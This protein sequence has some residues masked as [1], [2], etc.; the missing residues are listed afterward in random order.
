MKIGILGCGWVGERLVKHL[1]TKQYSIATTNTNPIKTAS[2]LEKG[3]KAFTLDF[4]KDTNQNNETV[5]AHFQTLDTIIISVPLSRKLDI[6]ALTQR[7]QKVTN[8]LQPN[9]NHQL[10]FLSSIG[11]Y[12]N[13]NAEINE[14]FKDIDSLKPTIYAVETLLKKHFPT[15]N[16][17]RLGGIFGDNRIFSKYF[18]NRVLENGLQ[19][20][21]H[22]HYA[23]IIG[24]IECVIKQQIKNKTINI[25][26]PQHPTKIELIEAQTTKYK[27]DKPTSIKRTKGDFKIITSKNILDLNYTFKQPNPALF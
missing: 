26:A 12:P 6:L 10:I 11:I 18:S 9:H 3:C 4:D 1:K 15:I 14:D 7:F 13:I 2:N 16:I 8:F 23:D 24:V 21:N 19:G 22:V 25:V 27:L 20:V 5:K 17:L